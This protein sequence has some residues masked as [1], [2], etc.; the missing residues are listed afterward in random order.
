MGLGSFKNI[1]IFVLKYYFIQ[2][3]YILNFFWFS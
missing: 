3:V 2:F 1:N